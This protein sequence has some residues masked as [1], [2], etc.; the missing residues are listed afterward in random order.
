MLL[1]E[2]L[3]S[4]ASENCPMSAPGVPA[5]KSDDIATQLE[6]GGVV[7]YPSCPFS[8]PE[9]EDREF[10]LRQ[11][12]SSRAHKNISYN[13]YT[14]K[15]G[16]FAVQSQVEQDRL[17]SLLAR[18]ADEATNWLAGI[19][20]NYST[21]W[22]RDRVSFRPE[23]EATRSLRLVARNDLLHVDAFP[24]RP[25]YG[26]RILRL[27]VNINPQEPRVWATAQP[28]R[29][30][31]AEFSPY[32]N[33]K[34]MAQLPLMPRIWGSLLSQFGHRATELGYDTFMRNFHDFLKRNQQ[35]QQ[36]C[37]KRIWS[38]EPGSLW[39]AM[40]DSC[41]HSVLRGR[42]ALEHSYF[43]HPTSQ[44]LPE[45][46]PIALWHQARNKSVGSQGAAA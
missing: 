35:F 25:T 16:G 45:E 20:P 46:A 44:I 14:G 5:S 19:L 30:L 8:I 27:F 13:P 37:P 28:F 21:H 17:R 18:F 9:G 3:C 41:S 2:L 26:W 38:F 1:S 32:L 42:Y 7:Y 11:R 29:Q 4:K 31:L 39:L 15:V 33:L 43:I 34:K 10:L 24:T 12:L 6:R 22:R 36:S 40:T 23:E